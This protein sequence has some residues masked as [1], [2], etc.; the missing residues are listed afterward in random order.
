MVTANNNINGNVDVNNESKTTSSISIDVSLAF[1]TTL[2]VHFL[3]FFHFIG[4]E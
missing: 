1:Q 4:V 3:H 2:V